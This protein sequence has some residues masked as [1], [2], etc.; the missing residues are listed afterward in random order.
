L[1]ASDAL[2]LE[3]GG[4]LSWAGA[5]RIGEF[6]ERYPGFGGAFSSWLQEILSAPSAS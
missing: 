2:A 4:F 6:I 5:Q 1:H 3:A